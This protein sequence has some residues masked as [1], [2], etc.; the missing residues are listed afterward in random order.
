ML[1]QVLL[2]LSHSSSGDM[3]V[4]AAAAREIIRQYQDEAF[5]MVDAISFAVM[6]RLHLRLDI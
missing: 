1:C 2:I 3:L 4:D 6:Q 5:S